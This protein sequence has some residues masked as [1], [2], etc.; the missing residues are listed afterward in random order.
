MSWQERIQDTS[1]FG[2]IPL[3]IAVALFALAAGKLLL[4]YQIAGALALNY[5][6]V[7]LIRTF[8][9]EQRPDK[10]A[11]GKSWLS[12]IDASSFPSLHAGRIFSYIIILGSFFASVW[13]YILMGALAILISYLRIRLKRHYLQDVAIGAVMGL[14]I[15][16]F[17]VNFAMSIVRALYLPI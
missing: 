12:K 17:A 13:V 7:A 4:F 16:W 6:I 10:T 15:G 1:A 3:G 9:F 14:L 8:W 5:I 11:A 2:G